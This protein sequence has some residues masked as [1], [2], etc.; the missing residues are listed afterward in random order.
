MTQ[1]RGTS[2]RCPI[3]ETQEKRPLF[4]GRDWEWGSG[5]SFSFVK[6]ARCGLVRT[7]PQPSPEELGRF[8]PE[9]TWPRV[10]AEGDPLEACV[11]G[12]PWRQLMRGRAEA[13]N[14]IVKRD[15]AAG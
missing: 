3:C 4:R 9:E 13:G 15:P 11:L 1:S 5:E 6:C 7:E 12:V 14:G 10:R 8:Y 2:L